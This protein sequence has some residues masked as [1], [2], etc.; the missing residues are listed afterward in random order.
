MSLS[1]VEENLKQVVNLK[2]VTFNSLGSPCLK[3]P[4]ADVKC[5]EPNTLNC[6]KKENYGFVN[7]KTQSVAHHPPSAWI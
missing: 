3:W 1:G 5:Q 2:V 7:L 4:A 6:S